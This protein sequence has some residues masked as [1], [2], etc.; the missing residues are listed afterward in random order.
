[1]T[2][3]PF[4]EDCK[5]TACW[6]EATPRP[7]FVKT[8]LPTKTDVVIIGAG[9]TGL[10]ASLQTARGGRDTVIL[11]AEDLGRHNGI[12]YAMGYC[13]SGVSMAGYLG[14][15]IGQQVLGLKQGRTGFDGLSFQTRPFYTGTPWFLGASILYYRWLDGLGI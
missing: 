13:G 7:E 3:F 5:K 10:S 8:P 4:A 12:H 9:Y 15:R 1:M 11:D 6:W 14:M 2:G